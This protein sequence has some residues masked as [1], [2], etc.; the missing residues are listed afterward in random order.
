[1]RRTFY[2][3]CAI[4]VFGLI[5]VDVLCFF[6]ETYISPG[7]CP[8]TNFSRYFALL[9]YMVLSYYMNWL[10]EHYAWQLLCYGLYQKESDK[11]IFTIW[12]LFSTAAVRAV[13][14]NI[15]T[16][17]SFETSKVLK[18]FIS[19]TDIRRIAHIYKL[20]LYCG[21]MDRRAINC[22]IDWIFSLPWRGICRRRVDR[23]CPSHS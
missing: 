10:E 2:V 4:R 22:W 12:R 19:A 14:R 6:S 9:N 8:N 13:L 3:C 21:F 23:H 15:F 17:Y 20:F 18:C 16:P 11:K 7:V 5:D 1:M